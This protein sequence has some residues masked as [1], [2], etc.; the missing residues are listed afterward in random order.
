MNSTQQTYTLA[1]KNELNMYITF[2]IIDTINATREF[3]NWEIFY[4]PR[5]PQAV[6]KIHILFI[7]KADSNK[8]TYTVTFL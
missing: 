4:Y 3:W 6:L 1:L 7:Y 8:T 5:L 2:P